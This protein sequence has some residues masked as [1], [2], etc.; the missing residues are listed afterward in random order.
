MVD[1]NTPV[2][3]KAATN[4]PKPSTLAKYLPRSKSPPSNK[5][6]GIKAINNTMT[7]NSPKVPINFPRIISVFEIGAESNK[8]RVL[9]RRSS[10]ITRMVKRGVTNNRMMPALLNKGVMIMSVKPGAP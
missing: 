9:L 7:H 2:A 5:A 1:I 10:Q 6:S 8:L 3:V 4:K